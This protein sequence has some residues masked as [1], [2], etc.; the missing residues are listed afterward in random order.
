[1]KNPWV[2]FGFDEEGGSL[3]CIPTRGFH[4]DPAAQSYHPHRGK[5]VVVRGESLHHEVIVMRRNVSSTFWIQ[6]E[7]GL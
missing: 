5:E 1:M 6:Q 3:T 4:S 7:P 2:I